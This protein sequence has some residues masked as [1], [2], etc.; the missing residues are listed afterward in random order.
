MSSHGRILTKTQ[1]ES[2]TDALIKRWRVRTGWPIPIEYIIDAH[3][4]ATIVTVDDMR[5][6]HCEAGIAR[7]RKQAGG[8]KT[9]F[10][11]AVD[12]KVADGPSDQYH[13]T[14]A[15]EV[16]HF[17]LDEPEMS[18]VKS[19]HDTFELHRKANWLQFEINR[20]MFGA[21]LMMPRTRLIG[22]VK[23]TYRMVVDELGFCDRTRAEQ[24]I[25]NLIAQR[26][27]LPTSTARLRLNESID[28][29][30]DRI[31]HSLTSTSARLLELGQP[32]CSKEHPMPLFENILFEEDATAI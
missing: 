29:L 31:K 28:N 8:I 1:L 17:V 11:L 24:K 21:Y 4:D 22:L 15:E 12:S 9:K 6:S 32:N 25:V 14:L 10:I 5:L 18:S 7:N 19:I 30:S 2:E 13:L 26:V 16:A 23:E 27:S 20:E 3:C